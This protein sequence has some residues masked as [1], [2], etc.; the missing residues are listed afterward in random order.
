MVRSIEYG[1]QRTG[2]R[3][4]EAAGWQ[5]LALACLLWPATATAVPPGA[6]PPMLATVYAHDVDDVGA[7]WVSE[8]L[9]GAR[10]R[11][12]GTAL[13]TRGGM[14]IRPP[15]W[16]TRGWPPQAMDGELWIARDR[17]D[18][19]S[20]LV[21]RSDGTDDAG[22]REVRF[23]VFDLP[24]ET[25]G[26]EARIARMQRL[27]DTAGIDWLRPVRQRRFPDRAT[28]DAHFAAV[29]AAGGEGLMLHH[30]A[31][32]YRSGRSELLLKY[33]PH[34]DAEAQVVAHLPGQGR[35]AGRL[36]ALLVELPDGRLLRLGSGL[37]DAQRDD[38]P[39]PGSWVTYRHSGLT[40]RGMPRFARFLRVRDEPPPV[41][42]P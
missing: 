33:K 22:W 25:V 42:A 37:T 7:Y 15:H 21:R 41:E 19:V 13:W 18:A 30:R 38:P 17:F 20:A 6:P 16:F 4:P 10:A 23:L 12:D 26:F 32:P 2:G 27:L 39:P 34:D 3:A 11:W 40:T 36:G 35:H 24:D 28:L 5:A 8:K 14:R 31:A 9:D 29:V 1:S